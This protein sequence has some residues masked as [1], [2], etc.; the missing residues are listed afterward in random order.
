M[1]LLSVLLGTLLLLARSYDTDDVTLLQVSATSR[2]GVRDFVPAL[3]GCKE[4]DCVLRYVQFDDH[5]FHWNVVEQKVVEE[6]DDMHMYVLN[7]TS[8]VWLPKETG[9]L[10]R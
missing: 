9:M 7:M 8:Q 5:A 1:G 4:F 2:A 10:H 6:A 3:R